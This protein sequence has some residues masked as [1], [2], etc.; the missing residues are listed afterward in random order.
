MI[1]FVSL[2]SIFRNQ[3][4]KNLHTFWT[5][6]KISVKFFYVSN[7]WTDFWTDFFM[8]KYENVQ[9]SFS[10]FKGFIGTALVNYA[11]V[12]RQCKTQ[13]II[14]KGK[15]TKS[16]REKYIIYHKLIYKQISNK[17]NKCHTQP[18][19][20]L[21]VATFSLLLIEM[22]HFWV[23][24]IWVFWKQKS[25]IVHPTELVINNFLII[26]EFCCNQETMGAFIY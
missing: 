10:H 8:K 24:C 19:S 16:F 22:L 25:V 17:T 6:D 5:R 23:I 9:N 12:L 4:Y 26:N 11:K 20:P 13:E 15:E 7:S 1:A 3:G 18:V 14:T 21:M 2:L